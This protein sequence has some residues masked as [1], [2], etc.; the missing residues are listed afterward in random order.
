[1]E[2]SAFASNTGDVGYSLINVRELLFG[3]LEAA[4]P[5][6][7]IEVG[8]FRGELT[9]ELLRWASTSGARVVAIDPTPEPELAALDEGHLELELIR[10]TSH[11]ALR[12][13][14]PTDAVIIDGDHNYYTVSEELRLI[15][16]RSG[17]GFPL[18][19]FHDVAWPH[20]RRDAYYDPERIPEEHRQPLAHDVTVA[21]GEPGIAAVGMHYEWVASREGGP[22]NGVLT[23]IEDFAAGRDDLCLAVVPAFFGFGVLWSRDAPWSEAVAEIVGPWDRNPLLERLEANRVGQLV[24]RRQMI[25]M[26]ERQAHLERQLDALRERLARHEQL[27]SRMLAS[28][29]FGVAE[30]L[31]RLSQRGEPIFSRAEVRRALGRPQGD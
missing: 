7:V 6:S 12:E 2:G 28:R 14:P 21:P 8:A 20:G 23:A 11:G 24:D 9:A 4:A 10:E 1:V 26:R 19:M 16:E 5:A 3:C 31:S 27:L 13:A 30:W 18:V 25:A 15:G 29:A 17:E 22:R